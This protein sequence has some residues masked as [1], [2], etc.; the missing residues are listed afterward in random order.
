MVLHKDRGVQHHHHD[1]HQQHHDHDH[2]PDQHCQVNLSYILGHWGY[3]SPECAGEGILASSI[4]LIS[5]P[6]CTPHF[7][8]GRYSATHIPA[9][10]TQSW[11]LIWIYQFQLIIMIVVTTVAINI[12]IY[13]QASNHCPPASIT[14]HQILSIGR[15]VWYNLWFINHL[16][17]VIYNYHS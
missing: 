11:W 2:N 10:H 16:S 3:C 1:Q 12:Y 6:L 8:A 14:W 17:F 4:C 7:D 9:L 5:S 13:L 15:L